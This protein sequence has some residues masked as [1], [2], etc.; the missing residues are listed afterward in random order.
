MDGDADRIA[1]IDSTGAY[2]STNELLVLLYYYLQKVR[3]ERGGVTRNVATTHLLDRLA[4]HF[5][6]DAFEVPVGFKHVAASMKAY[7]I[8][9]AGES[10]GGLAI[11]GHILGKDGIFACALVVEM[12]ART[13]RGIGEMLSEIYGQIGHLVSREVNVP[14]T[15]D[16]KV[17]VPRRLAES[18]PEEIA[19]LQVERVLTTDGTKFYLENGGWLLLR[20]SGTEP[21]LRIF[22]EAE[23]DVQVDALVDWARAVVGY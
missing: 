10:S 18:T 2:V 3:G 1:I 7:D 6:E 12:I 4:A 19:G 5:G 23:N 9:L 15:P 8:L 11:R 20:F 13:G 17:I 21:L 16:L 22:A 14:A